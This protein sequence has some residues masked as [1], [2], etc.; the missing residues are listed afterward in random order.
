[1]KIVKEEVLIDE[2]GF[3][4]SNEYTAIRSQIME[5]ISKVVWPEGS[6][7]FTIYPQKNANG[8]RPIKQAFQNHLK[9]CGWDLEHR[10]DLGVARSPGPIDATQSVQDRLF[11]VEWETGNISWLSGILR[12]RATSRVTQC[13]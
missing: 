12:G 5:G 13:H 6:K 3:G 8:V 1:M 2:G 4:E 9:Q 7:Q 10:V 11:A